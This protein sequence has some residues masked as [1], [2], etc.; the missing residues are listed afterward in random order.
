VA[1]KE[2]DKAI[3]IAIIAL[4][5]IAA[6]LLWLHDRMGAPLNSLFNPTSA[7]APLPALIEPNLYT[8]P[9]AGQP[10]QVYVPTGF[11]SPPQIY[12]N[13]P[14]GDQYQPYGLNP[15]NNNVPGICGCGFG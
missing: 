10:P 2:K 12:G 15:V 13:L 14:N 6:V 5:V 4:L 3:G 9:G 1:L 11:L 7:A 8:P